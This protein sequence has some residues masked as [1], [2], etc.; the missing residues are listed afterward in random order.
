MY[1]SNTLID[2][3]GVAR[4]TGNMNPGFNTS[5]LGA[6]FT[7]T[8]VVFHVGAMSCEVKGLNEMSSFKWIWEKKRYVW[9]LSS[10]IIAFQKW[11]TC[12]WLFLCFLKNILQCWTQREHWVHIFQGFISAFLNVYHMEEFLGGF[13]SNYPHWALH[14]L[15]IFPYY[16]RNLNMSFQCASRILC[17]L[18]HHQRAVWQKLGP[19]LLSFFHMKGCATQSIA[20]CCL[21][22]PL[23][24][25]ASKRHFLWRTL[26]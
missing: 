24:I 14:L 26:K 8:Y 11:A 15:P 4:W 13:F 21:P 7:S 3:R 1:V 12:Y 6:H 5:K 9:L 16:L 20:S 2:R 18:S 22:D 10:W 23:C 17:F 25:T 19:R